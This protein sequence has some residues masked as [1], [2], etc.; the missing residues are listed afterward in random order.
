A[1]YHLMNAGKRC[2]LIYNN[3]NLPLWLDRGDYFFEKLAKKNPRHALA[4]NGLGVSARE[5][6]E[7]YKDKKYA[8]IA[9]TFFKKAIENDPYLK[10]ARLN[11]ALLLEKEGRFEAAFS[12]YEQ[13]LEIYRDDQ[14]ML[15][16]SGVVSVNA[17]NP[18]KALEF[19]YRLREI[20]PDYGKLGE[21]IK[22]A[23]AL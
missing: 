1:D 6:L 4:L 18:K 17:G 21:Y 2:I 22:Q 23:E 20:N 14:Q 10:A 19:W 16:N 8:G 13:A 15:F 3:T 11:L 9:E 7:L 12:Q 5:K